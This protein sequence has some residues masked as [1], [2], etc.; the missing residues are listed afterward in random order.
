MIEGRRSDM[1]WIG[2][3]REESLEIEG[4]SRY[5]DN[6]RRRL[7]GTKTIDNEVVDCEE[8]RSKDGTGRTVD[9]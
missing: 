3:G 6:A 2:V 4:E 9:E 1:I 7:G 8:G 5:K